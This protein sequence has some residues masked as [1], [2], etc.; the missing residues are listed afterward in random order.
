MDDGLYVSLVG[1]VGQV[2]SFYSYYVCGVSRWLYSLCVTGRL[3]SGPCAFKY[4]LSRS[5]GVDRGGS[6]YSVGV[7][8]AGV[9]V[10]YYRV[11]IHGFQFH[12]YGA[13]GR[14]EFAGIQ[15]ASRAGV[16]S[17]LWFRV[18]FRLSYQ[19]SQL[20]VLQGLRNKDDGVLVSGSTSSA[21]WSG[22]ASILSKRVDGSFS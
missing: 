19:L 16:Y 6:L 10:R 5:E 1:V 21:F 14:Y 11:V 20:Y 18:R 13:K 12:V 3:V 8:G 22:L 17:C 2:S 9:Q 4:A 15:R 7:G